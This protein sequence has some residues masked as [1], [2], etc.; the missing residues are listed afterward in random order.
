MNSLIF[1][2]LVSLGVACLPAYAQGQQKPVRVGFLAPGAPGSPPVQIFRQAMAELGY[3]EGGNLVIEPRF[4]EGKFD[5]FPQFASELAEIKVDVVAMV[6]AVTAR[7]AKSR[8]T[9]I[10]LVFTIV[11]DPVADGVLASSERPGANMTGV[12]T[13]DPLQA[14]KRLQLLREVLPHMKRVAVLGDSGVSEAQ[15][16]AGE[17][18]A[19]DLGIRPLRLRVGGA[20]P[21][22]E[23]A[24]KAIAEERADALLV[25]DE[26]VPNIHSKR[27]AQLAATARLPTMFAPTSADAG[28][29]I[30]YGT[31]ITEAIRRMA[32][33][34]DKVIKGAKPG[35]LAVETVIPYDLTLNR[36]TARELGIEFPSDVLKRANRVIE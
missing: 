22:L 16:K 7:A 25:L 14:R 26:P 21:D 30:A 36:R 19:I 9:D 3:V 12:T 17:T 6:G 31:N 33:V 32:V 23:G 35:E 1:T 11:V 34:V 20:T 13:F 15:L 29:L 10:P 28:A 4:A 8:V 27:I 18:A 5:R 2:V 24:F